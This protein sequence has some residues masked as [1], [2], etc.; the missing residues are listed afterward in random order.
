MMNLAILYPILLV[1]LAAVAIYVQVT[2]STL[3]L[4]LSTGTTVLTILLPFLAAANVFYT[5][6]LHRTLRQKITSS[7][8]F[9]QLLPIALQVIQG[10]LTVVLATLAAEGFAGPTLECGLEGNWQ[11]LWRANDGRAIERIQD[12]FNC[13]GLRSMKD[14]DWPKLQCSNFNKGRHDSCLVPWRASMQRSSG[15]EFGIAVIVGVL[16]LV[17]L[18]LFQLRNSGGRSARI[19]YRRIAQVVGAGPSEA[20]LEDGN[21]DGDDEGGT[22]AE[23]NGGP[24][25]GRGEYGSLDDGPNHRIEPTGLGDGQEQNNWR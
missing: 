7:P 14:K 3:S 10:V 18:A 24:G 17:H 15:F 20:L 1:I 4:P 23:S 22:G 12:S 6:M 5:P 8:A 13:C 19:G 9:L 2:A 21:A 11:R 16:Q 25:D